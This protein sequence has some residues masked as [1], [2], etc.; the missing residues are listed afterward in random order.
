[1]AHSHPP[2]NARRNFVIYQFARFAG[3]IAMQMQS[4]A[5]G[6][7]IYEATGRPLFLGLMGLAIFLPFLL[8]ALVAGDVAD[9][10]P[11]R[12]ILNLCY[13]SLTTVSLALVGFTQM[14][15]VAV[16][17][18]LAAGGAIG[19]TRAFYGPAA[20]ALLPQIVE[21]A[22]LPRAVAVGSTVWQLAT[23]AGPAVG[24]AIYAAFG[25]TIVYGICAALFGFSALLTLLLPL[26]V[27][28]AVTAAKTIERMLAGLRYVRT[29][30]I[31][32]G[33]ISLDL[34]AVLLGGAVALLPAVAKD[35]LQ[36]G[37][38]A[39]GMLRASPS[40]GAGAVALFLAFR[41]LAGAVGSKLFVAVFGFGIAT[42]MFGMAEDIWQAGLLLAL[43]GGFDMIS[44]VIRQT[45]IQ[46]TTPDEMRGRVSSVNYIFIGASNELGEF[47]SGVTA[48]IFGLRRAIVIGGLGTCLIAALWMRLFPE[49]VKRDQLA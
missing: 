34:F 8:I 28:P 43:V 3:T 17:Q 47:E 25:A 49:L 24:G 41:P 45:L 13:V 31:V 4:L 14:G 21:R 30:P 32:L 5:I 10:V 12:R 36:A 44:V 6:W 1:M 48:E 9:R 46:V 38:F 18:F 40:L 29:Q 42:A 19:L 2:T 7:Q 37:P 26:I 39:L 23:I 11:R 27:A 15:D 33:A 22:F 20:S 35:L 16:W